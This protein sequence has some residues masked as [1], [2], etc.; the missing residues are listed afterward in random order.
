[1]TDKIQTR[2]P[3]N[4][5]NID[6]IPFST[7]GK[8][9]TYY[10]TN[11][12]NLALR[13]GASSKTFIVYTRPK[14]SSKPV[15]ITLGKYGDITIKHASDLATKELAKIADGFN[16]IEEKKQK[17]QEQEKEKELAKANDE[18]TFEW[19]IET[20]KK[21]HIIDYKKGSP[22]T[23]HNL[24]TTIDYF[25]DKTV[26]TLK[27]KDDGTWENYKEVPLSSW[28]D[29]PFRSI[30]RDD[31]LYRFSVLEKA[32]PARNQKV[33]API[34]RTHQMS[35][36]FASSAFNYIIASRELDVKEDLRNPFD[37][38][39]IQKKWTKTGKRTRF[40]DFERAEFPKW[41]KA[42]ANY[43]YYQRI[44]SDYLLC[45]LLQSGRSIDLAP[46]QW[47]NVDM[48][49]KRI[50]YIDTKNGES[51]TYP[52]TTLV[53]EIFQRRLR[54]NKDTVHVFDYPASKTGHIPQDCQH[55]FKVIAQI[56]GKTVSH[57][58]L[59]RTWATAA[60]KLKLDER[61]ID[62]CL[63]H[64]RTDVNEHYFV[65]N[66]SEILETLQTVEDFFIAISNDELQAPVAQNFLYALALKQ[67]MKNQAM[68][69][70]ALRLQNQNSTTVEQV[71][72]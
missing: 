52:M 10:D 49:L 15:R 12:S 34:S 8:Q 69:N 3:F 27:Q 64:K 26:M 43:D 40:V 54:L 63:K 32:R 31:V 58:D 6:A 24:A 33:L 20:Y 19:M 60:R 46:L 55:H 39:K 7:D 57:H 70:E 68:F 72:N 42:V 4:K 59:R 53:Y 62:Y 36:K 56:S 11:K 51:Y 44:V 50:H 30:T 28:L 16:P 1:M 45:S 22:S 35:F 23:L 37:V 47:K 29:R 61:N 48:E 18:Q 13:V 17:K 2:I 14:G 65:R 9:I 67:N 66:E 71:T 38:M 5:T 25:D 41:W 21:E